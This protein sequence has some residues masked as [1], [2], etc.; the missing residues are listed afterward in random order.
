VYVARGSH[1]SYFN[2]GSFFVGGKPVE[3]ERIFGIDRTQRT[4][5]LEPKVVLLPNS[6]PAVEGTSLAWLRFEGG[7]GEQNVMFGYSGPQ[8]PRMK[9][10]KWYNPASWGQN[11]P[12]DCQNWKSTFLAFAQ[13]PVD[14]HVYDS[15]GRHVGPDGR[16][17][18]DL[19]IPGS[20]YIAPD[21]TDN[22][23]ILISDA[24][25]STEEYRVEIHGTDSGSCHLTILAPQSDESVQH[26]VQYLAIPVS[27]SSV[28][29]AS[30]GQAADFTLQL[31]GD[32]DG[33]FESQISPDVVYENDWLYRTYLPLV[34]K[35]W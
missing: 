14:L 34:L 10:D 7:W 2:A 21:G 11:C 28:G 30:V 24:D 29:I 22:K 6:E 3:P 20:Q 26:D 15:L 35:N 33:I 5:R 32:G 1:A 23:A 25:I 31:D 9:R 4:T 17:G 8:G 18:I 16:G 19:E 13:S 27:A 12:E